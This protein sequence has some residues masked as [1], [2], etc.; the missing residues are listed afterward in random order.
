[1]FNKLITGG[2]RIGVAKGLVTRALERASGV[3]SAELWTK[4]AGSWRPEELTLEAITTRSN[5]SNSG[6]PYPFFL[7]YPLE[8]DILNS[9][10]ISDWQLD[11]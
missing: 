2:L 6:A 5:S 10:L 4:L 11:R 9:Y 1:M 8:R 7:A 3:P